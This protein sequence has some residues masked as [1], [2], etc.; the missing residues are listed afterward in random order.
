[1]NIQKQ[2]K[3]YV[4]KNTKHTKKAYKAYKKYVDIILENMARASRVN[5]YNY[6]NEMITSPKTNIPARLLAS[7]D[8]LLES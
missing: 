2:Q 5:S 1:M 7:V 8:P 4:D 6:K 3:K